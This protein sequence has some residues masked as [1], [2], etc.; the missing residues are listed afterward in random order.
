MPV[1]PALSQRQIDELTQAAQAATERTGLRFS[2]FVGESD[3]QPAAF[4]EQ[5]LAALGDD[6]PR[7]VVVHVDPA[8]FRVE[9]VTGREASSRLDDRACGLATLS[10]TPSFKAGDI[11][12]GVV[13]GLR[14]L[15][16]A[17]FWRAA[18]R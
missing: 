8:A 10:M 11:V 1:G 9:I 13:T 15:G 7:S 3:G 18:A 12:A 6:A 5:L 14:V 2:V 16:D 4:A 17:V